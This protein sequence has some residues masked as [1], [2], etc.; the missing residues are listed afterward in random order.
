M[1]RL[2]K[3]IEASRRM[4]EAS[5]EQLPANLPQLGLQDD[6]PVFA[7]RDYHPG[8][9]VVFMHVTKSGGHTLK[10]VLK[11][12]TLFQD[13]KDG[14]SYT[15]TRGPSNTCYS[16]VWKKDRCIRLADK[17]GLFIGDSVLGSDFVLQKDCTWITMVR[18]PVERLMS[19]YFMC[20][21]PIH[22][23]DQLCS[24]Y[25]L[26][27]RKADIYEFADFWGN[28]LFRQ[29]LM[30]RFKVNGTLDGAQ[31]ACPVPEKRCE[32]WLLMKNNLNGLDAYESDESREL[33][34]EVRQGL[35]RRWD[36]VG[37]L[38]HFDASME[39]FHTALPGPIVRGAS[40]MYAGH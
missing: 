29:L 21:R 32:P 25:Q 15:G 30:A 23:L 4:A 28:N 20:Q 38:E 9:C 22:N 26:N 37:V 8:R 40:S 34:Q 2:K 1:L 36:L 12:S 3:N 39:L 5:K 31:E 10:D 14:V 24:K 11:Y 13:K 27:A 6:T 16:Y 7:G 17:H 35:R 33:L 19:A 18:H